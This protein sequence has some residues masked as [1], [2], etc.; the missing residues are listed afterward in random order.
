MIVHEATVRL[1]SG[2]SVLLRSPRPDDA[3]APLQF[4][5]ALSHESWRNLGHPAAYFDAFDEDSEAVIIDR[6]DAFA[7]AER[8][9]VWNLSLRVRTFNTPAIALY[10]HAGFF[11]V[12]TMQAAALIEGLPEDEHI[13]QRLGSRHPS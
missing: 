7:E 6:Y 9:G 13:Y 8:V 11:R 2:A 12:G 1:Q 4:V 3:G 5:R 10:E